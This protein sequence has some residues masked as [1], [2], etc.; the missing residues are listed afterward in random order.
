MKFKPVCKYERLSQNVLGGQTVTDWISTDSV[1]AFWDQ[2]LE[3]TSLGQFQQSAFWARVKAAD[4]WAPIRI[5]STVGDDIISGFQIL[6]RSHWLGRI[7]YVS[8]GPVV[9][10]GFPGTA[11]YTLEL[12]LRLTRREG[13][14]A[15]VIQPPD[16]CEQIP[17]LLVDRGLPPDVLAEV[18]GATWII[19]L[20]EGADA[21]ERRMCSQTRRKIK[22]AIKR[23]IKIREGERDDLGVF[24]ELMLAT[25]R[26]QGVQ[27]IP[28]KL[29]NMLALWDAAGP[30][31]RIR[32][33]LAECEGEPLAGLICI[34][35]GET[36]NF[37][38]KGW[39][40]SEGQRNPNE[41]LMHEGLRWASVNGFKTADFCAFDSQIASTIL[42]GG[43]LTPEQEGSRHTFHM[44]LGGAPRILPRTSIYVPNP[45]CRVAYNVAFQ[46]QIRCARK[47]YRSEEGLAN[48]AE[49][50]QEIAAPTNIVGE[51]HNTN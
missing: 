35:F 47:E 8:K 25:C 43:A 2:F 51:L 42:K 9:I 27:P 3:L 11:E 17:P 6:Q 21:V 13:I 30:A 31:R 34:L 41:L 19:D 33:T 12:L 24:F 7:G 38:K 28:A 26:R 5:L 50:V 39:A 29:E 49:D 14:R 32:I 44:R 46:R 40:S 37:W 10:P 20:S 1:D 23:N 15:L 45:L 16:R 18:N 36:I 22:L 4:G 48:P